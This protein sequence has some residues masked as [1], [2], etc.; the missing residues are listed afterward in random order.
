MEEVVE[1]SR[2]GRSPV[3][4][5]T[6]ADDNAQGQSPDVFWDHPSTAHRLSDQN[7]LSWDIS[8]RST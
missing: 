8:A 5:L 7:K 6:C 3:V 2:P 4:R 1:A